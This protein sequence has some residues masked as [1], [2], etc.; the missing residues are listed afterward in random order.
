MS[1]DA[2]QIPEL[3]RGKV[4]FDGLL[5][6]LHKMRL[7]KRRLGCLEMF[8]EGCTHSAVMFLVYKLKGLFVENIRFSLYNSRAIETVSYNVFGP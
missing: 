6:Q 2:K 5:A 1:N 8:C 4:T 3:F 7:I